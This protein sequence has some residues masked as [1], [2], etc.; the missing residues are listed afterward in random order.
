MKTNDKCLWLNYIPI[1]FKSPWILNKAIGN[2]IKNNLHVD[3][4][5]N[6]K[7]DENTSKRAVLP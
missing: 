4:E 3:I 7:I 6:H 1:K 2:K 5:E